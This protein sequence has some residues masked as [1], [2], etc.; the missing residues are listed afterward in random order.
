MKPIK[1]FISSPFSIGDKA[2][3]VF[4]QLKAANQLMN[5]GF[6]PFVP[7]LSYYQDI[8]FPRPYQDWIDNDLEWLRVC[9]VVLRLPGESKGADGEV[10]EAIRL[11]IQV[12]YSIEELRNHY[13]DN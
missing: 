8:S 3:N 10:Q 1:V 13:V 5:Y 11:G 4:A 12:V 7:L 2:D 6:V 9:D